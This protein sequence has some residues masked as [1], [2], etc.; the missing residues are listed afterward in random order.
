MSWD[1]IKEKFKGCWV[2][3]I[4]VDWDWDSPFP[5]SAVVNQV[6]HD[7]V[8]IVCKQK[9]SVNLDGTDPV[10]IFI[11]GTNLT[12]SPVAHSANL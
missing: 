2:E 6:A 7:R 5:Q 11:G 9:S 12:I 10:V 3:L 4:E 8:N 1:T